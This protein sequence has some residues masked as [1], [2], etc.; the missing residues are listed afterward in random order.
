MFLTTGTGS[1]SSLLTSMST[2]LTVNSLSEGE[3][4]ASTPALA[5]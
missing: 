4:N 5:G 2:S 3:A 1:D